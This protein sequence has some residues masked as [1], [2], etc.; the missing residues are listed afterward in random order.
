MTISEFRHL[1]ELVAVRGPQVEQV[2]RHSFIED[3]RLLCSK[4]VRAWGGEVCF[5]GWRNQVILVALFHNHLWNNLKFFSN[6]LD[7][8]RPSYPFQNLLVF[9]KVLHVYELLRA[10]NFLIEIVINIDFLCLKLLVFLVI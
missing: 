9:C 8:G 10:L 4:P 7:A 2:H 3:M 5:F 6:D 1:L